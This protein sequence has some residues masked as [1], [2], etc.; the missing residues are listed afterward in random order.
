MGIPEM[1]SSPL[2]LLFCAACLALSIDVSAVSAQ[3]GQYPKCVQ[4]EWRGS[5]FGLGEGI[6]TA[7]AATLEPSSVDQMSDNAANLVERRTYR[8]D[9]LAV[10]VIAIPRDKAVLPIMV[11]ATTPA[12]IRMVSK[13]LSEMS[14]SSIVPSFGLPVSENAS[15]FRYRGPAE[16]CDEFID[17]GFKEQVLMSVRWSFCAE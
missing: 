15:G 9:G 5:I 10:T 2:S 16:S 4:S 3:D 14:R 12:A 8:K 7:I 1:V 13:T 11:E 17:L 6:A